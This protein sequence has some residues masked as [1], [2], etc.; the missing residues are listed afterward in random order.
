MFES[1]NKRAKIFIASVKS[2]II[3]KVAHVCT[4]RK[5]KQMIEI[6]IK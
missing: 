3:S 6:D 2:R 4:F 5:V 1:I